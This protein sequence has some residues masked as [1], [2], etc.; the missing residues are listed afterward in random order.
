MEI[1][2]MNFVSVALLV[3]LILI[4]WRQTKHFMPKVGM[5]Q[6]VTCEQFKQDYKNYITDIEGQVPTNTDIIYEGV[7]LPTRATTGSAGYDFYSPV[8][9]VLHPGESI[10]FPTGI[11]AYI[12][13]GWAL[14]IYPRSS[15]GFK[16]QTM[17]ANTVGIIDCDYYYGYNEGHIWVKLVNHGDKDLIVKRGDRVVQGIFEP[18]GITYG[19]NAEAQ[20]IGG[21]GSSGR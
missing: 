1:T 19:D 9:F 6:R 12:E 11:R 8:A 15:L 16:Y 2:I 4:T 3:L 18:Y 7:Q 17:L 5:F 10:N 21:F 20:R 13:D 14:K